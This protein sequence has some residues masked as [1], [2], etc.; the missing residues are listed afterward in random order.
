MQSQV[1]NVQ[2]NIKQYVLGASKNK[3]TRKCEKRIETKQNKKNYAL[4]FSLLDFY[5]SIFAFGLKF[6]FRLL[7]VGEI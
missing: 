2:M 3:Q 6:L 5:S 4:L 7:R 1:K